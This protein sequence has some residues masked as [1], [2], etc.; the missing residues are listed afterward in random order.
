MKLRHLPRLF[1]YMHHNI[2]APL[3]KV[4]VQWNIVE[5]NIHPN[6]QYPDEGD[7]DDAL[8]RILTNDGS[9][10]TTTMAALLLF[11]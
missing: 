9:T 6:Q 11:L 1:M 3:T 8:K 4:H 7:D 5:G 2:C 10:M